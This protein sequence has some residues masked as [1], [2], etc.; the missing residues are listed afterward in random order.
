MANLSAAMRLASEKPNRL[1]R[2]GFVPGA[3][4]GGDL[5]ETMT[6]K[7]TDKHSAILLKTVAKGNVMTLEV[8]GDPRLVLFKD[9][10]VEPVS[11]RVQHLEFLQL[12][13]GRE[14]NGAA[15][16]VL[17]NRELVT[18]AVQ[19]PM[20]SIPHRAIPSKLVEKVEID[21]DGMGDGSVVRVGDL[22]IAKTDGVTLLV[23]EDEIVVHLVDMAAR[24]EVAE[25]IAEE[26]EIAEEEETADEE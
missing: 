20:E 7:M 26:A 12:V 3:I 25:A 14:V 6:I 19:Q 2:E 18:I 16:V 5:T 13:K 17:K 21:L 1:R 11:G 4:Y 24:H 9:Y 23:S 10:K 22:D 8:E 15:L